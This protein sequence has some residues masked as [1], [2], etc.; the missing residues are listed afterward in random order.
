[1]LLLPA[2]FLRG[3]VFIG[4]EPTWNPVLL[5]VKSNNRGILIP[6]IDIPDTTLA[7]PVT[8]PKDGLLVM[9]THPGKEGLFFWNGQAWEKLKTVES[10]VADLAK[11]GKRSIFIGTEKATDQQLNVNN[12][13]DMPLKA[14]MGALTGNNTYTI[15]E[16]GIYEVTAG[17][18]GE[19]SGADGFIILNI[20]NYTQNTS[21]AYT[22][23][24]QFASFRNI[25]A[26]AI[27]YGPLK[28]NDQIG[29]RMFYGSKV[30]GKVEKLKTIILSI[31]RINTN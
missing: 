11:T 5:E 27:Y 13:T 17:F 10:A 16:D 26:K 20:H 6:R 23:R 18:T 1:M 21:L 8:S 29:I 24:N 25:A 31:K 22:T 4:T 2:V 14:S 7:A 9:N 19:P 28:K 12:F 15:Q 30:T 3:Q